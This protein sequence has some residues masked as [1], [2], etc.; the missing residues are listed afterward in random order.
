M[1]IILAAVAVEMIVVGITAAVDSHYPALS[2]A[3][4]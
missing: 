2:G 1:A 3:T 4:G